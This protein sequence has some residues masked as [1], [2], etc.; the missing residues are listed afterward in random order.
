MLGNKVIELHVIRQ[1]PNQRRAID[2]FPSTKHHYKLWV[3]SEILT[4]EAALNQ[5]TVKIVEKIGKS[6][7]SSRYKFSHSTSISTGSI[8]AVVKH[9]VKVK[10][11]QEMLRL[12]K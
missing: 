6:S 5:K 7:N 4:F 3:C 10:E 9:L 11:C 8:V 1:Q 2:D 12:D